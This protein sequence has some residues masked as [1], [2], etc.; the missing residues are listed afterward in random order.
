MKFDRDGG[1]VK[2]R[3]GGKTEVKGNINVK[4]ATTTVETVVGISKQRGELPTNKREKKSRVERPKLLG[5]GK[6]TFQSNPSTRG[7]RRTK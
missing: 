5:G 1:I 4:Y 2:D 6:N 7:K 3:K